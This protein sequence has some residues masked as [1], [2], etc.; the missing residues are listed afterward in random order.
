[1]DTLWQ[2][3]PTKD[4]HAPPG[5]I[6][7]DSRIDVVTQ[8]APAASW[9]NSHPQA[10]LQFHPRNSFNYSVCNEPQQR[11]KLQVHDISI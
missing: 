6:D 9:E 8:R 4:Q 7:I 10:I 3:N 5:G 11:F 2:P 1:M